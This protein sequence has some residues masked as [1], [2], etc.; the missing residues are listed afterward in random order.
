[1]GIGVM[2]DLAVGVHPAGA[3][4]WMMPEAFATGVSVGAPP[5]MYNQQG[6]DWSQPPFNPRALRRLHYRPVRDMVRTVMRN[7]GA[8][9]IDH[10][11]GFFRLWW[12]P[13]GH[14]PADGTYVHYDQEAMMG[15]LLLEAQRAGVTLVGEDLGNVEPSV[16][17]FLS[18]RGVLGTSVMLFEQTDSGFKS[19]EQ[20]RED[21]L[22]TVDTHDLPPAAGYLAGTH[23]ELRERLGLLVEPVET[24]LARTREEKERLE[25]ALRIQ[26]LL[27][28]D[29]TDR[30]IVLAMHQF[31]ARTPAQL[32]AIAVTD[33]VGERRVQNQPGTD[34]EYPNWRVPLA[35]A[36]GHVV[37][38]EDFP[39]NGPL[40]ALLDA[41]R[42]EQS[43][44]AA[45]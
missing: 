26:G 13:A 43:P 36:D 39:S 23:V 22:T 25:A 31:I 16:R 4:T 19:P 20:Y 32:K 27:G 33:A 35:D 45:E 34:Q 21:T 8:L 42:S 6:Q 41:Y 15:V 17:Q 30:E 5:D 38:L 9:R 7:V 44:S 29:P 12:I 2:G 10:V 28:E 11:M 14:S 37:L 24:V 40:N 1:M 18:E 3:D